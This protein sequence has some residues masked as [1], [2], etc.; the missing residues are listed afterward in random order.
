M[1][2]PLPGPSDHG[3]TNGDAPVEVDWLLTDADWIVTCDP[4]MR[5]IASAAIA[6]EKDKIVALGP[7]REV[8]E[9]YRGN[10]ELSLRGSLL[11]PG[12]IN[13]HTHAAMSVFRG[14]A[15]DLPLDR[16]LHEI[17]FPAEAAHVSPDLVYAGSLLSCVEMLKNGITTF[18]DGYFFEEEAARAALESGMRAVL[19][20]GILDF[21]SPDQPDP[22]M[23]K[24]R[25]ES[26]LDSFPKDDQDRLHP[27]L[28]CHAC[29]TCGPTT[30]QW[31]KDFCRKR[32]ILFQIHI[33]E[34]LAEI[35]DVV[36]IY[37]LSP[38]KHLDRLGVLDE[39]TLGAH[40]IWIEEDEIEILAD[41]RVAIS[42]NVESNMKL[43]S[44]VSPVPRMLGAGI[45]VGL[46]ADG[47]ASNNHL[48]LFKEMDK[49]A[50]LHKVY[51]RDP[52]TCRASDVLRM[53]T[54]LG[55]DAL[56][57]G[58]LTGS[59]E[60]GKKADIAAIDLNQ[61]HLTPIYDPISHLVYS[62]RGSDVRRVWVNGRQIVAEGEVK[63]VD[64]LQVMKEINKIAQKIRS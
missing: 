43:A 38:V 54:R 44:G 16:W 64:S 58:N 30:L 63:S 1:S 5:V 50:K 3:R 52:V 56:G 45:R 11:M 41:R 2:E 57:L 39:K 8:T 61:P 47:C 29:Y 15:D 17:I 42:H 31:T 28:F 23:R 26:F 37:G 59:L 60:V 25:V 14:F 32:D 4:E 48:D 51:G 24:E 21:P 34:T 53:A 33:S 20:Q 27:S 40:A 49:A 13:T 9:R 7:T 46:G 36:K 19:G 18:C 6:L 62:V 55:A 12:L 10:R 35:R 22:A